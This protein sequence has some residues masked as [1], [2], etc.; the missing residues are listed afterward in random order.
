VAPRL[1]LSLGHISSVDR[2]LA[3]GYPSKENSL[4]QDELE[5]RRF[6]QM[7]QGPPKFSMVH[8]GD[9]CSVQAEWP[10]G[11]IETPIRT[12]KSEEEAL[13][14]ISQFSERWLRGRTK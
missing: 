5:T 2:S 7:K 4:L 12:L 9:E 3:N 10:D 14:W 1:A 11:T 13:A 8:R 6:A